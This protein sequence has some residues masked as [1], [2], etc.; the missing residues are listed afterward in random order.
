M[1]NRGW[2]DLT[3]GFQDPET[4]ASKIRG[5]ETNRAFRNYDPTQADQW[6]AGYS[7]NFMPDWQD[8]N[9]N[10]V[11]PETGE[12]FPSFNAYRAYVATPGQYRSRLRVQPNMPNDPEI[13]DDSGYGP[14]PG[15]GGG[16]AFPQDAYN[17]GGGVYPWLQPYQG[18][19]T[20]PMSEYE[21]YALDEYGNFVSGGSGTGPSSDYYGR[22]LDDEFLDFERN[23]WLQQILD[24]GRTQQA[25]QDSDA[26]RRI[27]SSMAAGGMA[28]SGARAGAERDYLGQSNANFNRTMGELFNQSYMN[29]RQLQDAAARGM[30]GVGQQQGQGWGNLME[31]G[32][33]PRNI[34]Q[35]DYDRQYQ[36]WVRQT[37]EYRDQFRYPDQLALAQLRSGYPGSSDPRYGNST[38]DQLLPLL[39]ML[40]GGGGSG[41]GG[42]GGGILNQLLNSLLNSGGNQGGQGQGG[43][44]NP[45]PQGGP[46]GGAGNP[47]QYGE[48]IG[49][50]LPPGYDPET[51]GYTMY[52]DPI[53]PTYPTDYGG[54]YEDGGGYIDWG[55]DDWY[56]E[57]Y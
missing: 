24:S 2:Q 6:G 38:A 11:N 36:D 10:T 3:R 25:Y 5:V 55:T 43:Y 14:G 9:G 37:G 39:A 1:W 28:L 30:L 50:E 47:N 49:P 44:A 45:Y 33:V 7:R 18:N 12:T 22:V 56:D 4:A 27:G 34:E 19:Y 31:M 54:G 53:G 20:A 51:G 23:P 16:G 35:R 26:L 13:Q 32:A 17:M 41:S 21:Q 57:D 40:L 52:E 46:N 29:E 48:P 42:S 15:G 8:A